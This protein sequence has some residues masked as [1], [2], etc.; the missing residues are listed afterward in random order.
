MKLPSNERCQQLVKDLKNEPT[1]TEWESDFINSYV[2]T[3]GQC[4]REK[5]WRELSIEEKIERTNSIVRDLRNQL[6]VL[7]RRFNQLDQIVKSHQHNQ[8]GQILVSPYN[9]PEDI[10]RGRNRGETKEDRYF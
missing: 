8:F 2:K 3:I 9:V 10:G 5:Y 1:L 4:A 6:E 7:Q